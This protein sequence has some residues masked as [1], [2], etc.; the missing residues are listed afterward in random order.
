MIEEYADDKLGETYPDE[1]SDLES[2]EEDDRMDMQGLEARLDEFQAD[3]NDVKTFGKAQLH[4]LADDVEGRPDA[5]RPHIRYVESDPYFH[6]SSRAVAAAERAG[7]KPAGS[8]TPQS[9]TFTALQERE[10]LIERATATGPEEY[11]ALAVVRPQERWDVESFVT[12]YTNTEHHPH[13]LDAETGPVNPIQLSK[14]SQM[15]IGYG[16]DT[17]LK[18]EEQGSEDSSDEYEEVEIVN[19]GL[20]RPKTEAKEEKKLRKQQAK[21]EKRVSRE[22]KKNLKETYRQESAFQKAQ[23]ARSSHA[24]RPGVSVTSLS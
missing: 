8:Q 19:K 24:V 11:E 6:P 20:A 15:P 2:E 1:D 3:L 18:K 21:Q 10:K 5:N 23:K 14:R 12:T 9:L 16:R 13:C 4:T 7:G 22:R 17:L